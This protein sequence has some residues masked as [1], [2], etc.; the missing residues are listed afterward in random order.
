VSVIEVSA[1]QEWRRIAMA[2]A[3]GRGVARSFDVFMSH[4]SVDKAVVGVLTA[5]LRERGLEPWLDAEQTVPGV[6]F[7]AQ[8][9][10][11][12]ASS[13]CVAVFV[14][15]DEVGSWVQE[16]LDVAVGRAASD[17]SF[18]VFLVLLPSAPPFFDPSGLHPFLSQRTWVDLRAVD[19]SAVAADLLA[20]AVR[21]EPLGFVDRDVRPGPST[22]PY[23]GLR[24]FDA[25]DVEWFFGREADTQRMAEKLRRSPFLAVLGRSGSGKSS[26]VRAG[27]VPALAAGRLI[28]GSE[29]WRVLVLRPRSAPLEEL[30]ARVSHLRPDVGTSTILDDLAGNDASLK[31]LTTG[32]GDHTPVVW[33]V[34]QAEEL[35]TLCD[36][37]DQ[38]RAFAANLLH[39]SEASGP[40]RVVLTLRS[41]FYARFADLAALSARIASN[42]HVVTDLSDEQLE[43]AV[44]QP[45]ALAGVSLEAGLVERIIS[46]VHAQAGALPLLQHAL[47]ETWERRRGSELTHEA[48]DEIGGVK[49]ALAHRAD[50][51]LARLEETGDG[52][53]VRHLML[54]MTR[55]G[56][57]TEDTKQ[58]VVLG[59]LDTPDYSLPRLHRVAAALA[60]ARLVTTDVDEAVGP[61]DPRPD[62][63]T[64]VEPAHEALIGSWPALRRWLDESRDELRGRRRIR[65]AARAWQEQDRADDLLY[66]GTTL[67]LA[68]EQARDRPAD[69]PKL[70]SEFLAASTE[71]EERVR[72]QA[73]RRRVR[74]LT[75]LGSLAALTLVAAVVSS[76]LFVRARDAQHASE[77]SAAIALAQQAR[78][79]APNDPALALAVSAEALDRSDN[80]ETSGALQAAYLAFGQE[81]GHLVASLAG[82]DN[83]P[84]DV[85]FSH[86]SRLVAST[87]GDGDVTLWDRTTGEEIAVL[88]DDAENMISASVSVAFSPDDTRVVTVADGAAR[89]WETAAGT[90]IA[91]LDGQAS[92]A[93]FSPDG[94]LLAVVGESGVL[95]LW[96]P[97]SGDNVGT[98]TIASDGDL[99]FLSHRHLAFSPD[100]SLLAITDGFTAQLWDLTTGGQIASYSGAALYRELIDDIVF[101]TE[102]A[103]L[104]TSS[105]NTVILVNMGTGAESARLVD[106]TAGV[107]EVD[108]S[109]DGAK[110]VAIRDDGAV[111][112]WDVATGEDIGTLTDRSDVIEDTRFSPDGSMVATSTTDS[113]K[114]WDTTSGT[115]IAAMADTVNEAVAFNSD[116]TLLATGVSNGEDLIQIWDISP[117][118][119]VLRLAGHT[120]RV[121]AV[122]FN[123]DSTMVATGS[124]D[125]TAKLW[126]VRSATSIA[127]LL[128]GHG[129]SVIDVAF[130]HDGTLL[131]TSGDGIYVSLWNTATGQ[132]VDRFEPEQTVTSLA[133]SP[134]DTLL[135]VAGPDELVTLWDTETVRK[136]R[137]LTGHDEFV[138]AV[139][140]SPD[141]TMV[142]SGSDDRTAKL[143]DPATGEEISTLAG[144]EGEIFGVAFN[145]DGTMVATASLDG[146]T[147]VWEAETG[148]NLLTLRSGT[149]TGVVAFDPDGTRLATADVQGVKLWDLASGD[150]VATLAGP[151]DRIVD[152]EFNHD[153]TL[154]AT[155][156]DDGTAVVRRLILTSAEACDLIATEVPAAQLTAALGG[157]EPEACRNLR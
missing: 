70:E 33:V 52:A 95:H 17:R 94:S 12:L 3:R 85:E 100:G 97:S 114:V 155:A 147:K 28:P 81:R 121:R 29:T 11:G 48:Y 31:M 9:A 83:L 106:P 86:D 117:A 21:G 136:V 137:T 38:R 92:V 73:R 8:L 127:T 139:A 71:R 108:L 146:T 58:P 141:G 104:A 7:Q 34:D 149:A 20:R 150:E 59:Q 22:C 118:A 102:G 47:R 62:A 144:H 45:A 42:Q 109:P 24:S 51:V 112:L 61:G 148:D 91:A 152:V 138:N 98:L 64:R 35:F 39:V 50:E 115:E 60:D 37:P 93:A 128:A 72:S 119:N 130:N 151:N 153:G 25:D 87:N 89:L 134:D 154:L 26:A 77:E 15:G 4:S 18:R 23:V 129:D 66:R 41:D 6:R 101:S 27:L 107:A 78:A 80:P 103:L 99:S 10:D 5:Q 125:G 82:L 84:S 30:A 55:L 113:T 16:E 120:A 90:E 76:V 63:G 111:T 36:A 145:H 135:A 157:A 13:A 124:T 65:D 131:A 19:D 140:F 156:A 126:D 79:L 110:V 105:G 116:N 53:V 40:D 122:T 142:V 75:V 2:G 57:G 88:P 54:E 69:L 74:Q 32:S 49:G 14:G 68:R 96:D 44:T 1:A 46:D 132:E 123:G 56:E 143:W 67:A 133:F 43:R